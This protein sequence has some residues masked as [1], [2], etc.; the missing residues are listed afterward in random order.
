MIIS[1]CSVRRR[2]SELEFR[3]HDIRRSWRH[4]QRLLRIGRQAVTLQLRFERFWQLILVS[5]AGV[6]LLERF[7]RKEV[8]QS[9][10]WEIKAWAQAVLLGHRQTTLRDA[11]N[12]PINYCCALIC[13][14]WI[15]EDQPGET[16][17][18]P[19]RPRS[20]RHDKL[21]EH[22]DD[23]SKACERPRVSI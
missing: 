11:E 10:Q 22:G 16:E 18:V 5:R 1:Q 23:P 4:E 20:V 8:A 6:Q 3:R 12:D 9:R 7:G 19:K 14:R 21:L 2:S 17:M 13:C 15:S